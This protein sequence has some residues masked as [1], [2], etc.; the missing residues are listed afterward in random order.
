MS[1]YKA[2]KSVSPLLGHN[3]AEVTGIYLASLADDARKG[4]DF[5]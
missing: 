5:Q 2:K 1:D 4:G 3:R